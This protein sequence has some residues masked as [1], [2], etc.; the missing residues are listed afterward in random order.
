MSRA[1]LV[2]LM[3]S[4][5]ACGRTEA[6]LRPREPSASPADVDAGPPLPILTVPYASD[7]GR[8]LALLNYGV[9][10]DQG[11]YGYSAQISNAPVECDP[12]LASLPQVIDGYGVE[13]RLPTGYDGDAFMP[14]TYALNVEGDG[15]QLTV[16]ASHMAATLAG[17]TVADDAIDGTLQLFDADPD[18]GHGRVSGVE[19]LPDGGRARIG[20]DFDVSACP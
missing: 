4:L 3:L 14:G 19:H 6:G 15:G 9:G 5:A 10:Y 11:V 7:A 16:R 2:T 8:W 1:A 17:D 18:H 12:D 13:I 20:F